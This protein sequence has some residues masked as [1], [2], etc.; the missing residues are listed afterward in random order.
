MANVKLSHIEVQRSPEILAREL[1]K[2]ILGNDLPIGTPLPCE[3]DLVAQTGLSR[4]SVREALRILEAENLVTT[5]PGRFGGSIANRPG[6]E[7]LARWIS[8]FAHG[9]KVSLKSLLQTRE[10]LE[11]SLAALAAQNRTEYDLA[12]LRECTARLEAA[13]NDLPRFLEENV[14]WHIAIAEASHNELLR[15]FMISI[16]AIIYKATA[17]ENFTTEEVRRQVMQAHARIEEAIVKQDA[18][19][20][21]RRMSRHLIAVTSTWKSFPTAPLLIDL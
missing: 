3:R 15:A 21:R 10:E 5:R 12:Q 9:Q 1:R 16:S 13:F 14:N 4:S 17:V 20:A 11:P 2:Q 6:D 7:A 19:A 8:L 18:D